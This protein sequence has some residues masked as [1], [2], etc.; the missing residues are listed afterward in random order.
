MFDVG[1]SLLTALA[2]ARNQ[3][4]NSAQNT[5]RAEASLT[6]SRPDAAMAQVAACAVF[7]EALMNALHS[8]LAEIKNVTRQ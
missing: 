6:D 2:S 4:G 3:L 8:R 5:A 1:G 7:A